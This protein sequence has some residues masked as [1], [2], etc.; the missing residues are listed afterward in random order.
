MQEGDGMNMV[1]S[2]SVDGFRLTNDTKVLGPCIIFPNAVLKW[3]VNGIEDLTGRDA[4][5]AFPGY[6]LKFRLL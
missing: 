6:F 2:Y 5:V 3:A 4:V 1:D